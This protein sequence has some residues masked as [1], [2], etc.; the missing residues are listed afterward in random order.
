MTSTSFFFR[1]KE[2]EGRVGATSVLFWGSSGE[3]TGDVEGGGGGGKEK[4]V[5]H[6]MMS[7]LWSSFM[8]YFKCNIRD[9][10][11]Y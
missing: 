7:V 10:H 4:E 6:F 1:Y 3:G 2:E 5:K 8:L 9:K 11:S